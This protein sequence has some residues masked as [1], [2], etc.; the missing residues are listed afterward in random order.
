MEISRLD[1]IRAGLF[2]LIFIILFFLGY[3]WIS[4]KKRQNLTYTYYIQLERATLISKGTQVLIKGVPDGS[5]IDV[6]LSNDKVIVK[7]GLRSYQLREGAYAQ[8]ITPSALGTR[9]IDIELGNGKILSQNDTIIGY[10]SPTFDQ[11]L[12]I[13]MN[14]SKMIDSILY[15]T[16]KLAK[17]ANY[18][19]ESIS[20]SFDNSLKNINELTFETRE[21][22]RKQSSN[23]D[24]MSTNVNLILKEGKATIKS[25]DSL[26]NQIKVE[27][28][29]LKHRGTIGKLTK[30]DSLYLELRKSI[31][32]LQELVDD[33]KKNPSRYINVKIF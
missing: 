3:N 18:Q 32:K 9:M 2:V 5:V 25:L 31:I 30:D 6:H 11:I 26:I 29:S 24:S 21:I 20:K 12:T 27:V 17:N 33:V 19:I 14:L 28:D 23:F 10:D 15:N 8:V 16:N 4:S 13:V 1:Y 7:V 22:L